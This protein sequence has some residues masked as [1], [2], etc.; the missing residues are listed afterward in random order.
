[1]GYR[2]KEENLGVGSEHYDSIISLVST[3]MR[4]VCLLFLVWKGGVC[5]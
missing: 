5:A 1:M 3:C 2:E 4:E